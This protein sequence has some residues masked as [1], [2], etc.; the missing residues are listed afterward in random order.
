MLMLIMRLE[1]MRFYLARTLMMMSDPAHGLSLSLANLKTFWP[2]CCG[3][4]T[5]WHLHVC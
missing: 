5:C 1:T 4:R 2:I 3:A